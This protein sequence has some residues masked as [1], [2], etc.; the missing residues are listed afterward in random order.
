V[1][2]PQSTRRDHEQFCLNESWDRVRDAR[3]RSGT[4]HVTYELA[5]ADGRVLRTRVS[6]PVARSGYGQSLWAHILRDQFQV[7]E[8]EFWACAKNGVK[9]GR[10]IPQPPLEALPAEVVHL[11]IN[12]VSLGE[13]EVR[14]MSRDEANSPPAALLGGR[15][16]RRI[17]RAQ[18][19]P[20]GRRWHSGVLLRLLCGRCAVL[21]GRHPLADIALIRPPRPARWPSWE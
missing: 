2:W 16:I 21:P 10:G 15:T 3:G 8:D 7:S 17:A 14:A 5:L 6:H 1:N 9:A 12:R 18:P 4:H 20:C 11:L 19:C 13:D